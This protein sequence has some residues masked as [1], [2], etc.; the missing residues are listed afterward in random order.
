[1][2]KEACENEVSVYLF[3]FVKCI[4]A[5][6]CVQENVCDIPCVRRSVLDQMCA[7]HREM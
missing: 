7:V 4:H 1:V 3:I 5:G 6:A 2:C